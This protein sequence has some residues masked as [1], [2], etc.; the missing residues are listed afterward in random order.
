M[1]VK[2][3]IVGG[4]VFWLATFLL[5]FIT[6]PLIHQGAL[7]ATYREHSEFWRPELNMDPPDMAAL[8]PSWILYGVILSLVVG[9]LYCSC[10]CGEGP[11]WKRGARFGLG[12]GIFVC[13]VMLTWTGVF[14]LPG[15]IWMYWAGEGLAMYLVGG[16]AM[17]WAVGKWCKD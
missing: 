6:G 14:N 9:W 3:I 16:A 17:G 1:R 11:G 7:K 8:M 15:R 10:R 12:L 13:A 4:L 2:C 5:G